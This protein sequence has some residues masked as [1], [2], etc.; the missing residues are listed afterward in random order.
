MLHNDPNL[1]SDSLLRAH[2]SV[3][4]SLFS[5]EFVTP[6]FAFSYESVFLTSLPAASTLTLDGDYLV[7]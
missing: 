7:V 6:P 5:A 1:P 3:T 4:V 2:Q